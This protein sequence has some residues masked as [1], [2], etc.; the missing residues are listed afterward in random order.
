MRQQQEFHL[1]Y[2]RAL[3][4]LR[5]DIPRF[6]KGAPDTSIFTEDVVFLDHIG[7]RIGMIFTSVKGRKAYS[8]HIWLLRFHSSIIFSRCEVEVQRIWE[9]DSRT[10]AVRWKLRCFPR[11]L[12]RSLVNL[13]GI[14]EYKFNDRGLIYQHTVDI[15]NWDDSRNKKPA[16]RRLQ[17]SLSTL[18]C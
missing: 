3:R 16:Q 1:N 18:A 14:S 9:R 5:E 10:V 8:Q 11:L 4:V 12:D 15:I 13:D 6:F 17:H 2:G 7:P